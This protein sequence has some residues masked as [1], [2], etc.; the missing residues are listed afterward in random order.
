MEQT[1]WMV[2]FQGDG[3]KGEPAAVRRYIWVDQVV[4]EE[5]VESGE[6]KGEVG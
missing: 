3:L 4:G 1:E 2:P 6:Q 5:G